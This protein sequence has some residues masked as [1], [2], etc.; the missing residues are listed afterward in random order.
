M[1]NLTAASAALSHVLPSR[2]PSSHRRGTF[3][4]FVP[5]IATLLRGAWLRWRRHQI[6]TALRRVDDRL[7]RDVGIEPCEI[8]T[9]VDG[10]LARWR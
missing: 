9:I 6:L 8:D 1:S 3:T 4:G 10:L 5:L 2:Q 7:L